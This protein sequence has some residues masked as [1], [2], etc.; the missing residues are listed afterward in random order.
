[1]IYALFAVMC[2]Y[3]GFRLGYSQA[4]RTCMEAIDNYAKEQENTDE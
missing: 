2:F 3:G 1:M 4:K